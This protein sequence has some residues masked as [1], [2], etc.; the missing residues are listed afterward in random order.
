MIR[1]LSE[2]EVKAL[3]YEL[4]LKDIIATAEK[5]PPFPD[6]AWK[7]M[8][9]IKK[10]APVKEIENVIRYDQAIAAK[11]LTVGQSAYYGRKY[12]VSS[13]QDAI[14]LLGSQRLIQ[15]I[16]AAC[17]SR[18]FEGRI[19]GHELHERDLWEHSVAAALLSEIVCRRFK[20][21]RI[22]TVYTAALLHDIGKTVLDVYAKI[23]LRTTLRQI[24]GRS[25]SITAERKALGID[26]QE[27][28][29]IIARRWR[30]PAEITAAIE[31]HHCPQ[32]AGEHQPIAAMVYV[33]N[34][35]ANHSATGA[36]GE[37]AEEFD[38]LL[39]PV[40]RNLGITA[41]TVS[42]F[43]EELREGMEGVRRTLAL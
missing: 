34:E 38:P 24:S 29:G 4:L 40:F 11:L 39:D 2:N 15:V 42:V 35:L 43:Q 21:R 16:M 22:L 17:A 25:G 36:Q 23:Y 1:E 19:S 27:L 3:H 37:D 33:A 9:L 41:E 7:V 26:H 31:H 20:N 13:L 8:S 12:A 32:E 10:V 28:G 18:Y 14:L 6:V 5:L 30:L